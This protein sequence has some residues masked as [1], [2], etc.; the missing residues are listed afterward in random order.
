M[1]TKLKNLKVKKVDFVDAGANPEAHT[2]LWKRKEEM[3][4][5]ECPSKRVGVW[6]KLLSFLGKAAGMGEEELETAMEEIEKGEAK[7]FAE[8][9]KEFQ[10]RKIADEVWD[11]CYALQNSFCS[12]LND[13]ELDSIAMVSAM[14]E[15]LEEFYGEV[16]DCILQW[17]AGKEAHIT[18]KKEV[19][20]EQ[21]LEVMKSAV[22]R[23]H[24][25][26]QEATAAGMMLEHQET[27][28]K[29]CEEEKGEEEMKID[30]KK[31]TEAERAFLESIEKRYGTENS[32]VEGTTAEEQMMEGAATHAVGK[33]APLPDIQRTAATSFSNSAQ[34][35][36][37]ITGEDG[38]YKGLHPAV[39]A[40]LEEL[41]KFREAAEEK[42]LGQVAEK[43]VLIGKKKEE[44]IPLLKR[45]KAAGG[46]A[47]SD[48]ITVLDQVVETVEKS[49][50]FSEI[51]KSGHDSGAV[52]AAEAKI[53]TIAKG[54]LEKDSS[55]DYASAVAKAWEDHPELME[56]YEVEAGF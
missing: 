19:V 8:K 9:L 42:E 33:I 35:V 18:K 6:K 7:G 28:Q 11:V 21:D 56:E 5:V 22:E 36:A 27:I 20:T 47:Y 52:G 15:S 16:K 39:R 49:G 25:S 4:Q 23:L 29:N 1:A 34:P 3:E 54:Y 40:E 46:T 51:G 13:G 37:E 17:S 38:I 55:M 30:K 43:Y 32:S 14:Q 45:L 53:E 24:H 50:V 2:K 10:N 41:K 48:M 44:L 12:I 26:I 31:L